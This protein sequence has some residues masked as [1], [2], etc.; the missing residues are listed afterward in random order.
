[1]ATTDRAPTSTT[2]RGGTDVWTVRV[3][4]VGTFAPSTPQMIYI[5]GIAG[6]AALGL[7]EW[8][9]GL[10]LAGGH[11]LIADRSSPAARDLGEAMTDAA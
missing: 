4:A 7:L 6:M 10:A 9:I 2:N 8:P 11:L 1:M 5:G 3:P